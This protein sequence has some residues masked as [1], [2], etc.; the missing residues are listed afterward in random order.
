MIAEKL[1]L[2]RCEIR[3]RSLAK[4][5]DKIR[6]YTWLE[7]SPGYDELLDN[8]LFLIGKCKFSEAYPQMAPF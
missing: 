8:F 2:F 3:K 4:K 1:M 7:N 6:F 5:M